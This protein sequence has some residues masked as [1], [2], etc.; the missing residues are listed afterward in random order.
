[1]GTLAGPLVAMEL[2]ATALVAAVLATPAIPWS[3]RQIARLREK[4][5]VAEQAER[6]HAA[7]LAT[8]VSPWSNR[9][10][11]RLR[12]KVEVAEQAERSQASAATSAPADEPGP[13]EPGAG[14]PGPDEPGSG[15]PAG[16]SVEERAVADADGAAA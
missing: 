8:P 3:K 12:E 5:E 13:D 6:S 2:L 14:E 15:E 4:V 9:Q 1:M 11:A 7:G 10:I 16:E